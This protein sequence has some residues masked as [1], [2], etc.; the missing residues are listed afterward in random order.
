MATTTKKIIGSNFTLQIKIIIAPNMKHVWVLSISFVWWVRAYV[1][2]MNVMLH[3]RSVLKRG[4]FC[5]V[6]HISQNTSTTSPDLIWA[7]ISNEKIVE[8]HEIIYWCSLKETHIM[9]SNN[10]KWLHSSSV[11]P[12]DKLI[13]FLFRTF[14]MNSS[15]RLR[16][17]MMSVFVETLFFY[18]STFR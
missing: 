14:D 16:F 12:S 6:Y 10:P 17:L 8:Q 7:I 4:S 11:R 3:W 9:L 5:F 2:T 18:L 1:N 13:K 15:T